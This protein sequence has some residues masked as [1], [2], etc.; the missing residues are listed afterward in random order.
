MWKV[1]YPSGVEKG[2][3]PTKTLFELIE[4][5]FIPVDS[6]FMSTEIKWINMETILDI[7]FQNLKS[8]NTLSIKRHRQTIIHQLSPPHF[9]TKNRIIPVWHES[10]LYGSNNMK[11]RFYNNTN[12]SSPRKNNIYQEKSDVPHMVQCIWGTMR[13]RRNSMV[14]NETYRI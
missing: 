4:S 10:Q 11:D 14:G 9:S 1:K 2:P 12:K 5:G 7:Q 8:V 3:M 13:Q 6:V